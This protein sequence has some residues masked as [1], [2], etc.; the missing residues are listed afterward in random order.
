MRLLG[1][2]QVSPSSKLGKN[3]EPQEAL[4]IEYA[5]LSY[6]SR[7]EA[8]TLIGFLSCQGNFPLRTSKKRTASL[9]PELEYSMS[10][11]FPFPARTRR[12]D[13]ILLPR[14]LSTSGFREVS[15][16]SYFPTL[17][18]VDSAHPLRVYIH[19]PLFPITSPF[20]FY[21]ISFVSKPRQDG[22]SN[23]PICS[24]PSSRATSRHLYPR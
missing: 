24:Y 16:L 6:F 11:A 4:S 5:W 3:G 23:N 15:N 21:F 9:L 13:V 12:F 10:R 20:L 17:F 8:R 19:D 1:K 14:I 18:N 7:K 2:T 22:I